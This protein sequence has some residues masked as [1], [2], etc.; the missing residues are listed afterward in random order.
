MAVVVVVAAAA[1]G[2]DLVMELPTEEE[3][4]GALADVACAPLVEVCSNHASTLA[5]RDLT[6]WHQEV[7]G[8]DPKT[9]ILPE[10]IEEAQRFCTEMVAFPCKEEERLALRKI[11]PLE[12]HHCR[13][14]ERTAGDTVAENAVPEV[15]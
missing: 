7:V 10:D 12:S 9:A 8:G 14:Q 2:A 6:H 5:W 15:I 13:A 3:V 4:E 1:A 11:L